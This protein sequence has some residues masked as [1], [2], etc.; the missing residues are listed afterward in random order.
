MD[1][2]KFEKDMAVFSP[3]E[4]RLVNTYLT[5]LFITGWTLE[6][7]KEWVVE[8][9]KKLL[10]QQREMNKK[11]KQWDKIAL[12][13]S[14]CQTIM[15]LLPLNIS[16]GTQTEDDSKS[17]WLCPNQNCMHAIYN[18]ESVNDIIRKGGIKW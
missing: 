11:A 7:A 3:K 6:D 2:E 12:K 5:H 15:Q 16:P 10:A 14:L 1:I 4:H 18:K 8:H 9:K 13:C 17:V